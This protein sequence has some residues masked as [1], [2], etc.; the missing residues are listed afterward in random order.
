MVNKRV[1]SKETDDN[2][3]KK[4]QEELRWVKAELDIARE[5]CWKLESLEN[6]EARF[7]SLVQT[8]TDGII[9]IDSDGCITHWN[10]G[11][12]KIFGYTEAEAVGRNIFIIIPQ[13]IQDA[14]KTGI[15][16]VLHS[17]QLKCPGIT[18]ETSGLKKDGREVPVE[19]T[20]SRWQTKEGVFFTSI[21][22]DITER[23]RAEVAL[24]NNIKFQQVLMDAI[25][26]P[27]FYKDADCVYIGGNKAFELYIGLSQE[28]FIGKTVYDIAPP[29]L[30]EIY[31]KSDREA[32]K[33]RGVQSYEATVVY[34][35][36]TR[37]DV[38]FNKVVFS[39]AEGKVAGII[40]VMLDITDRKKNEQELI[41]VKTRMEVLMSYTPV[42]IYACKASG[43]FG[44]T[45]ISKN[46]K[47]Y[48]GYQPD[49]FITISN[50]WINNLHP[51]D[52][53]HVLSGLSLLF[54]KGQHFHEYRFLHKNGEYRW[55]HDQMKLIRDTNGE[56]V[57]I[58]GAWMD[59]TEHKRSEEHKAILEA[60]LHQAQKME[61][62][63]RLA[64]GVAHDFNN[65]L[66][67]ILGTTEIVMDQVDRNN[68]IYEELQEIRNAAM[69]SSNLTRQ[70][71]AFARK[72]IIEPIELTLNLTVEEMMK[73]LK[74]LIGEDINLIWKP[75]TNLWQIKMDPSQIDQILA[76]LCVNARDA[77]SGVGSLSIE[78]GNRT[79]KENDFADNGDFTSGEY[80][81]L[82]VS[83]DGSGIDKKTM[84]KLF[85]P[86]FTTKG[87][88]KG[89]GLGL[90]TVYGIVRQNKGFI[91]VC[92]EPG[93]GTTFRI[94]L[95]RHM[96]NVSQI[97][98]EDRKEPAEHGHE[99]VL[100]VEDEPTILK[101]GK[102]MLESLGYK[103]LTADTP[104]KAIS[105][106]KEY[107]GE[108]ALLITDVVM[109]E[110]SGRDLAVN[111]LSRYPAI[112]CL[113]MSGYTADMIAHNGVLDQGVHFIQKPFS[114]NELAAKVRNALISS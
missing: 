60:Q 51:E 10:S 26:A 1:E 39:D 103:V 105:I 46:I 49:E 12:E 72:Q 36:G 11:A 38:L 83:D 13:R 100:L 58:I 107:A 66:T 53:P 43:D 59:I 37:H 52:A 25:P 30:A 17:G 76:N 22:R 67:V 85:E 8:A 16:M 71:L 15:A 111:I 4:L 23:K 80:V 40:G 79:F 75:G 63:G 87:M 81:M 108:I 110:M 101:M 84:D 41:S 19:L 104:G 7:R 88:H 9:S 35:D 64:G 42:M 78:T 48:L 44:A 102:T 20:V 62:V 86:F 74:R 2:E 3:I 90:A 99:T 77:I 106:A 50:F 112:K 113:F 96:E 68:P 5:R 57:E 55:M 114:R 73:M 14:H 56:P 31:D 47:E 95:P 6:S 91:N 33:N 70:L 89:T 109:P 34:A 69:R 18:R 54:E 61:S 98:K 92:S 94:Y 93:K 29:D 21:I 28:Q 24:N 65:M 32:L 97:K 27:V 45:F 82:A